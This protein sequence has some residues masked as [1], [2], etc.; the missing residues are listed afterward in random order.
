MSKLSLCGSCLLTFLVAAGVAPALPPPPDLRALANEPLVEIRHWSKIPDAV[1]R[2]ISSHW[3]HESIADPGETFQEYDF[4]PRTGVT[5]RLLWAARASSAWIVCYE[6]GGIVLS[7]HLAMV[8]VN[9]N[10]EPGEPLWFQ[11]TVAS[12]AQ[13]VKDVGALRTAIREGRIGPSQP[14]YI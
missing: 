10:G 1:R 12:N 4:G 2:N 8:P 5:R 13:S 14:P 7:Q 9:A 11:F 3:N 6:H